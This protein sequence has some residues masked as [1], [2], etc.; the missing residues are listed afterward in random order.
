MGTFV[1]ITRLVVTV[2]SIMRF[3]LILE[4]FS[5][6]YLA[7]SQVLPFFFV[8]LVMTWLSHYLYFFSFL[9]Y[10][11]KVERGKVS[12]DFVTMSQWCDGGSQM[13]V[14]QVTVTV[15]HM[16]RVT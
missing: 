12:C 11:Y 16:M 5:S 14:S 15:G 13:V 4:A 7:V 8:N 3:C 9:I 10:N 6:A 1:L 2:Y